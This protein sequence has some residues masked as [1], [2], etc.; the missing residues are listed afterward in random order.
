MLDEASGNYTISDLNGGERLCYQDDTCVVKDAETC[1][2]F[3]NPNFGV[4]SFD[5]ILLSVLNIFIIITLEGWTDTMYMIR[6][7]TGSTSYDIFF[8][9]CVVFGTFFVLNLMIAV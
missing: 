2:I 6:Q 7:T 3:E 1:Q 4:T 8:V 5:N 9:I